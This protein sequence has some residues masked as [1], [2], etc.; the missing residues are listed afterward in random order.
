MI[1]RSEGMMICWQEG[2]S[3]FENIYRGI[4]LKGSL[5]DGDMKRRM[6]HFMRDQFQWIVYC[7][8]QR[9]ESRFANKVH[10]R[11]SVAWFIA[12]SRDKSPED[13]L[14]KMSREQD[15][16]RSGFD[17]PCHNSR[18]IIP[19]V[20]T[21]V[22]FF[23]KAPMIWWLVTYRWYHQGHGAHASIEGGF[24]ESKKAT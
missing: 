24:F 11:D 19:S 18:D 7:S 12:V 5:F 20:T 9:P 4:N 3:S 1:R 21:V 10:R 13:G 6:F 17:K 23:V 14:H 15:G 8:F 22:M 2:S 16:L